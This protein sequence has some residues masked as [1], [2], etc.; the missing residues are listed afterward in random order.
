[1]SNDNNPVLSSS[2][3][4]DGQQDVQ[5]LAN[6][7]D[8]LGKIID[9]NAGRARTGL[10][11][12]G[13]D[14]KKASAEVGEFG[15]Q[16]DELKDSIGKAAPGLGNALDFFSNIGS[17]A[18]AA[19]AVLATV[20]AGMG[21]FRAATA[22]VAE[23]D[24]KI[25]R[26]AQAGSLT[27]KTVAGLGLA[28]QR[29]GGDLDDVGGL[30][31]QFAT[32]LTAARKAPGELRNSFEAL[33][34]SVADLQTKNTDQILLQIADNYDKIGNTAERAAAASAIFGDDDAVKFAGVASQLSKAREEAE[35]LGLVLGRDGKQKV[36]EYNREVGTLE[37]QWKALTVQ[38][39]T[40]TLPAISELA[41]A[42]N[43]ELGGDRALGRGAITALQQLFN[44]GGKTLDERRAELDRVNQGFMILR[45]MTAEGRQKFTEYAAATGQS[46]EQLAVLTGGQVQVIDALQR[47]RAAADAQ[48]QAHDASAIAA[49]KERESNKALAAEKIRLAEVTQRAA[50]TA[51]EEASVRERRALE[52]KGQGSDL[53]QSEI[54]FAEEVGRARTEVARKQLEAADAEYMAM[55]A[56]RKAGETISQEELDRIFKQSEA[57]RTA[58]VQAELSAREGLERAHAAR[59]A[60]SLQSL[61]K[62]LE[63]T[64]SQETARI[65]EAERTKSI[66]HST[67]EQQR[68]AVT[69]ERIQSEIELIQRQLQ[70]ENISLS[71]K[72]NLQDR[73][74]NLK[75][76]SDAAQLA[77]SRRRIQAEITDETEKVSK[78]QA[79]NNQE[80]ARAEIAIQKRIRELKAAGLSEVQIEQEVSF[81]REKILQRQIESVEAQISAKRREGGATV[82]IINLETERLKIEEQ[83]RLQ[84]EVTAGVAVNSL[85]QQAAATRQVVESTQQANDAER[86]R[87]SLLGQ[88]AQA[89]GQA[90]AA[91]RVIGSS[92]GQ[93]L[94]DTFESLDAQIRQLQQNVLAFRVVWG[95]QDAATNDALQAAFAKRAQLQEGEN[96][97]WLDEQQKFQEE[98]QRQADA[99]QK[100]RDALLDRQRS[101]LD[102]YNKDTAAATK[103]HQEERAK[104]E[105]EGL[106]R[107]AEM[108]AGFAEDRRR[109]AEADA[110]ELIEIERRRLRSIEDAQA[111]AAEDALSGDADRITERARVLQQLNEL[112]EEAAWKTLQTYDAAL[113]EV[114]R[115]RQSSDPARLAAA[116]RRADQLKS[117]ADE[118]KSALDQRNR[119]QGELARI[120][121]EAK[122]EE[123]RQ[124][125][126]AAATA[127]G[128]SEE[129]I[130]ALIDAA[131]RKAKIDL[132]YMRRRRDIEATGNREALAQLEDNYRQQLALA[133]SNTQREIQRQRDDAARAAADR[134]RERQA[135]E[136]DRARRLED[137]WR[138]LDDQLQ[139][140]DDAHAEK[141]DQ[142]WSQLDEEYAAVDEAMAAI[143][144]RIAERYAREREL[145]QGGGSSG[146]GGGGS[147]GSA[148]PGGGPVQPAATT[149]PGTPPRTTTTPRTTTARP[150]RPTAP[151]RA[152]T[153]P[154]APTPT[155]PV[156]TPPPPTQPQQRGIDLSRLPSDFRP[157]GATTAPPV[158]PEAV[159]DWLSKYYDEIGTSNE[160]NVLS[161]GE[162]D[163]LMYALRPFTA[164]IRMVEDALKSNQLP[165]IRAA[166]TALE[167]FVPSIVPSVYPPKVGEFVTRAKRGLQ[168]D[169][170]RLVRQ[171]EL[172][173]AYQEAVEASQQFVP[174][175][176]EDQFKEYAKEKSGLNALAQEAA[177][178]PDQ[179][180]ATEED[181]ARQAAA[182]AEYQR[183]LQS[184]GLGNSA[185][186]PPSTTSSG[187][188]SVPS[189]PSATTV[190]TNTSTI[191]TL[192][193]GPAIPAVPGSVG[194]APNLA[195]VVNNYNTVSTKTVIVNVPP[196]TAKPEIVQVLVEVLEERGYSANTP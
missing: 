17:K 6:A 83:L 48:R 4:I 182:E 133:E 180:V 171:D 15:N 88:T 87:I 52:R 125:A 23:Y 145:Q 177:A 5:S 127:S 59:R 181:R 158:K 122:I 188:A 100:E 110:R 22:G 183:L 118:A 64:L 143:E 187:A 89:A 151:P 144:A 72:K 50:K 117:G 152:T 175:S 193:P 186:A 35:K 139:Q 76:Q 141:M 27:E 176:I 94:G 184:V 138:G 95:L 196:G 191:P 104:I 39:G 82:E 98:A 36:A 111:R 80:N 96:Q 126:I 172:L 66:S 190:P 137:A 19:T 74:Q 156:G 113:A 153:P 97:R 34:V 195:S 185:P 192:P 162:Q 105:R 73:I 79:L 99:D 101:A 25:T 130:K 142:L 21:T 16:F 173:T 14:A 42:L 71:E 178:R 194:A 43:E 53:I 106:K 189:V 119:L 40:K 114:E 60:D 129:E 166:R 54:K 165:A 75:V 115:A 124:R 56:R 47:Q 55:V 134:A 135:E 1:M 128:A 7:I 155:R 65:D 108:E 2:I 109:Q 10:G 120:D 163:Q 140:R 11:S 68:L 67:A 70:E 32:Q 33:G 107:I 123:E 164:H 41:Q 169:L 12:I 92:G 77:S 136:D 61:T 26:A 78:L 31:S 8:R 174:P 179:Y 154:A 86:E 102:R 45:D 51:E 132:D 90:A 9:F 20:A 112:D 103:E 157:Q 84:K 167:Q 147:G 46:A 44:P 62:I 30:A 149:A 85:G 170:E 146:T 37:A 168:R 13:A 91:V 3:Q 159:G 161:G 81:E 121:E 38:I 69:K 58:V 93:A 24:Q 18:T 131:D 160:W 29:T 28:L 49:E 148:G 150:P 57:A 116:Q 63:Q